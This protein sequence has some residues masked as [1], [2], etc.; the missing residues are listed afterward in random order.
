M[1]TLNK[2]VSFDPKDIAVALMKAFLALRQDSEPPGSSILARLKFTPDFRL[3]DQ[4]FSARPAVVN[5]QP[6]LDS[7]RTFSALLQKVGRNFPC[8][9]GSAEARLRSCG[10]FGQAKVNGR[11]A[12]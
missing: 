12:P 9:N 8:S 2:V 11:N 10:F 7:N 4:L 5:T 6:T 3:A 1:T